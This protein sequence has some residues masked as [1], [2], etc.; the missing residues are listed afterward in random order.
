MPCRAVPGRLRLP[1]L[2]VNH[3]LGRCRVWVLI[4]GL[5]PATSPPTKLEIAFAPLLVDGFS[6]PTWRN[7]VMADPTVDSTP[8]ECPEAASSHLLVP[9]PPAVYPARGTWPFL[10]QN[11]PLDHVSTYRPRYHFVGVSA[12]GADREEGCPEWKDHLTG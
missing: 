10:V 5:H 7:V 1:L 12:R 8:N 6:Y 2:I 4:L 11:C 3:V 9:H